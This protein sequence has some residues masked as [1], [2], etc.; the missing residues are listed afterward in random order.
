MDIRVAGEQKRLT[1]VQSVCLWL[2]RSHRLPTIAVCVLA[3]WLAFRVVS[4]PNGWLAY[5]SK[6]VE[7]QQLQR[8]VQGLQK[9]NEELGHRV[10]ALGSDP[11]AIEKEAR[12]QLRYVRPG[13]MVYVLPDQK[14]AQPKPQQTGLAQ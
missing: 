14:T 8:E 12:E 5:H 9:Q 3:C 2:S 13:E 4:G 6:R 7:Y 11:Q 10:K 1:F